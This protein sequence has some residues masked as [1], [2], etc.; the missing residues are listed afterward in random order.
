MLK[1]QQRSLKNPRPMGTDCASSAHSLQIKDMLKIDV[2]KAKKIC[3]YKQSRERSERDYLCSL[4]SLVSLAL[5]T[6]KNEKCYLHVIMEH[7]A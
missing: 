5:C 7:L 6:D 4:I 2:Y 1:F 3:T